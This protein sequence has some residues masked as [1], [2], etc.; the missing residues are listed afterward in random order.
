MLACLL[1]YFYAK[2]SKNRLS[3]SFSSRGGLIRSSGGIENFL[4]RNKDEKEMYDERILGNGSFVEDVYK[5]L[6]MKDCVKNNIE[7]NVLEKLMNL[8]E[9]KDKNILKTRNLDVLKVKWMYAYIAT[10]YLGK[11][12]TEIGKEIGMSGVGV[13][14]A[15]ILEILK[16]DEDVLRK[17]K[18]KFS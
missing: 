9:L 1:I 12:Y 8:Y 10:E 4:K 17:I 14:R 3:G 6:E 16:L 11:N 7:E 2:T 15:S 13:K 5:K 18:I